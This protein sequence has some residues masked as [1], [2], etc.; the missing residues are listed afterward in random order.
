ML[1]VHTQRKIILE[2]FRNHF[3]TEGGVFLTNKTVPSPQGDRKAR[4]I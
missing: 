2:K 1:A 4:L 3:C